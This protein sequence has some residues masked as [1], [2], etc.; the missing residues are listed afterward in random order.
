MNLIIRF[1]GVHGIGKTSLINQIKKLKSIKNDNFSEIAIQNLFRNLLEFSEIYNLNIFNFK[2]YLNPE[3]S[4]SFIQAWALDKFIFAENI[5][6]QLQKLNNIQIFTDRSI[7]DVLAYIYYYQ[8]NEYMQPLLEKTYEKLNNIG[9]IYSNNNTLLNNNKQNL[10]ILSYFLTKD[11]LVFNKVFED[12]ELVK[13]LSQEKNKRWF[14]KNILNDIDRQKTVYKNNLENFYIFLYDIIN[15]EKALL[16]ILQEIKKK[17]PNFLNL[18]DIKIYSFKD[19]YI[20]LKEESINDITIEHL[21]YKRN[22]EII[23]ALNF[24]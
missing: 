6:A 9:E 4:E 21:L 11:S 14:F 22:K 17:A 15:F 8:I 7:I 1:T 13:F 18:F 12:E 2:K 19:V 23:E 5:I 3:Y 10:I 16:Y 20:K 24:S